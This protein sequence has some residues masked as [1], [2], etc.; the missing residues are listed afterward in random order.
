MGN[1]YP[2]VPGHEIAG[3]IDKLGDGLGMYKHMYDVIDSCGKKTLGGRWDRRLA[4]A[5]MEVIAASVNRAGKE[6]SF[7]AETN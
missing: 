1:T 2:R 3:V 5:G 6:I 4:S 7:F